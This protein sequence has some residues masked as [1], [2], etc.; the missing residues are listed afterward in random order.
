MA[1][2]V[3]PT[4][5]QAQP[6]CWVVRAAGSLKSGLA[7]APGS[8]PESVSSFLRGAWSERSGHPVCGPWRSIG[9]GPVQHAALDKLERLA[10]ASA[11]SSATPYSWLAL[12]PRFS[13]RAERRSDTRPANEH[14]QPAASSAASMLENGA[15]SLLGPRF[16]MTSAAAEKTKVSTC[17]KWRARGR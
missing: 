10:G 11:P 3:Q 13:Q 17:Q 7:L 2:I 6:S 15:E 16:S 4:L 9:G 8:D 12:T 14:N 5:E 1:G